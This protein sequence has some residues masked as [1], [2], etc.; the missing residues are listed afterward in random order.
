MWWR[1]SLRL[2]LEESAPTFSSMLPPMESVTNCKL[3]LFAPEFRPKMLTYFQPPREPR[4][5]GLYFGSPN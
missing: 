4:S 1:R 5:L 3:E 2:A